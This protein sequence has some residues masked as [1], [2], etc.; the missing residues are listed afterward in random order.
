MKRIE[1]E[2]KGRGTEKGMYNSLQILEVPNEPVQ[3]QP[4]D[5]ER[6]PLVACRQPTVGRGQRTIG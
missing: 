3:P 1:S 6:V 2:K 5:C 4:G